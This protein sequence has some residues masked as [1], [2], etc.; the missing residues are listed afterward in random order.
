MQGRFSASRA[1][2][3]HAHD[4][5]DEAY[6]ADEHDEHDGDDALDDTAY[7][8]QS[9]GPDEVFNDAVGPI[10]QDIVS[11]FVAIECSLSDENVC[12][13]VGC[14]HTECAALF[15]RQQAKHHGV[16]VEKITTSD[17]DR[18]WRSGSAANA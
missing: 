15:G 11:A 5:T 2:W 13:V 16:G 9:C 17:L 12:D 6:W 3:S 7:M 4:E 14:F 8:C 18:S 1:Y 10:A